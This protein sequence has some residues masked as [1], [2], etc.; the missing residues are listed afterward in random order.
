[1]EQLVEQLQEMRDSAGAGCEAERASTERHVGMLNDE[2]NLLLQQNQ[3]LMTALAA[4]DE[5]VRPF[6]CKLHMRI[7]K[8]EVKMFLAAR[9]RYFGES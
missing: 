3:Q 6:V 7:L 9:Q 1:M 4:N 8:Q 2:V 5:M